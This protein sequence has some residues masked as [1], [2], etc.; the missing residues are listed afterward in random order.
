MAG[1]ADGKPRL[2]PIVLRLFC[3][4]LGIP[5]KPATAAVRHC[6][7][8]AA[9]NWPALIAQSL[10]TEGQKARLLAHFQAHPWM[11]QKA[12]ARAASPPA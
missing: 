11:R 4:R 12:I 2:G 5:E 7:A 8:A 3:D 6:V 9:R 10:L 1:A